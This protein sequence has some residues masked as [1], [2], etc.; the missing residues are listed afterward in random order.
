MKKVWGVLATTLFVMLL[1]MPSAWAQD[2]ASITGTV[3]D[4]TGGVI[5]GASVKLVDSRNG[6]TYESK[7]NSTGSYTVAQV[8]P[9]P[10]YTLT[11]SKD[12]FKTAVISSLYLAVAST[13]TQDVVLEVGGVNQSVEVKAE[14]SVSLNTT[15]T[16]IGNNFDLRAVSDLPAEFR[17]N[18]SNLLRLEPGV[19]NAVGADPSGSR[20]GSVAGARAD[21]NNITVD[22][23]DA[24][25]FTTG[26][27]FTQIAAIPIDAIQ[28]FTTQVGNP[29]AAFGRASGAQTV[30]TT[31]SGTNEWHGNA[32]EYNRTA[33]T[34]ANTFFNN[35]A[36]VDRPGLIR[37]QFGGNLGGPVKKDKLFFFFDY[38]GRRDAEQESLLQVVPLDSF[39]NGQ[40]G[41]IN[42]SP[43]CTAQS[44]VQSSPNCISFLNPTQ[45]AAF[46]PCSQAG[47]PGP[48]TTSGQAG[49]T[50]VTPG[51]NQALLQFINSRYPHVNDPSEG[52]GINTG[53]FRYNA[54]DPLTENIYTTRIDWNLTSKHK[55]F[56][57]F[58]FNNINAIETPIQFTGDPVTG[59]EIVQDNAWVL[60]ETWTISPST[61]N[62]FIYGE[63]RESVQFPITFNPAGTVYPL[64]W[65][66]DTPLSNPY[67]RQSTQSSLDPIPT[68]RDDVTLI[69]G[70]HTVQFG[71]VWKPIRTR[72][73]L[74]NDFDFINI[75]VGGAI[76]S[77][78][79]QFRPADILQ[80]PNGV[81][82]SNYDGYFLGLLGLINQD[83][84]VFNYLKDGT[85]LAH[86]TGERRDYRY[87]NYEAYAQDSWKLRSDLTLTYG[88]RYQ[89][90]S[91]PYET[92]GLEATASNTD[93]QQQL[94]V[95]VANGLAGVTGPDSVP[96]LTYTLAGKNN[97]GGPSL[98]GGDKLNFSPRLA[99]AW[100]PSFR[101]GLL[102]DIFGDR[103]T[104]L[105]AG[106]GLIYDQTAI[107]A[108]NF[109]QDQGSYLFGNL[110]SD[111]FGGGGTAATIASDPRFTAI[112]S[113]PFTLPAP[114]FQNPL[115]PF[116][117]GA[118]S[119]L[120]VN[121][122]ANGAF[123]YTIDPHFQTPYS[124][125]ISVGVQRELPGSFQL[126]VDYY[127]RF[128]RRLFTLADGAQ[129]VNFIDPTSQE[130]LNTAFSALEVGARTTGTVADQ[131][132][133]ENL[134]NQALPAQFGPG[135]T[136]QNVLGSSCTQFVFQ[137]FGTALQQGNLGSVLFALTNFGILP[138]GVGLPPQFAVNAYV[139]N[140]GW[141]NYNGMLVVL[142]KRLSHNLQW[143]FN[144]TFSH[145][146]DNSSLIANNN[147]NGFNAASVI[148]CDALHLNVCRG[149]SEFDATHQIVSTVIYDL[150]FGRN[151]AVGR[152]VSRW[153]DEIIGG[154][155]T[156]GIITWRSGLAFPVQSGVNTISEAADALAIF[157]GD[158]NAV[159]TNIHT[160]PAESGAIQYFASQ[161]AALGAFS[162]VTGLQIGNRDTLR[163]PHYSNVDLGVAKNFPLI[164]ERYRL[165]FRADAFN[166]FNH[167]NFGLPNA[168]INSPQF[169]QI[170]S[171]AGQEVSRVMQF[172]LR[173]QF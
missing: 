130:S 89:Y 114:A 148:T 53:G 16:T 38:E 110:N 6:N 118:G 133:F 107:S 19:V 152:N 34:E 147:G 14:G 3:T 123:N 111:V 94:A 56:T 136:C 161:T 51:T 31:K 170:T 72:S 42:D 172:S 20:D 92:N 106:A 157:N 39:R 13:R 120:Q 57:R 146:I 140:K 64:N 30:E 135:A 90:D 108:I 50:P 100:N 105:R 131:P 167:P 117:T 15:D 134:I 128:G 58:N 158:R 71:G 41:Y 36:G 28:E 74:T 23:I 109:L 98:Y 138:Q 32:H 151:Q 88:L 65:F 104:V 159:T 99:A 21:Q 8:E 96:L 95:R 137:N 162:P 54:P 169:G 97:P 154:W 66:P 1:S 45:I 165:Q 63:T 124:E 173:F 35:K 155:Q 68:F 141:S 156:S 132:F 46:D 79:P 150:P 22:G 49:G 9:G 82:D 171:L 75:G 40:L 142:R 102:G 153:L 59:P 160:D 85:A 25:D 70:R 60:G 125:T 168:D 5:Q 76:P 37:N 80:D 163:G 7:T 4:K 93:L 11:V 86:G 126:E 77:L 67:A 122:A 48:C 62:Q 115:T 164:G 83:Q 52:D 129:V 18:V 121:G 29:T 44:R 27:A 43:G 91:V 143:D 84:S 149:N 103:K 119:T 24:Q 139:S 166:A 26:A 12:S 69:R 113:L 73:H 78:S 55:I 87:F 33:A 144:Y 112:N 81:A 145:S 61:I 47:A 101:G 10:G 127:G 116:T 17:D 2:V